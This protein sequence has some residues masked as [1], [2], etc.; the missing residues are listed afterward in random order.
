MLRIE[1]AL[2]FVIQI[3]TSLQIVM[4][5]FADF[6]ILLD[7]N[8]FHSNSSIQTVCVF[9]NFRL[10]KQDCLIKRVAAKAENTIFILAII[11]HVGCFQT[12]T[13][14]DNLDSGFLFCSVLEWGG[15]VVLGQ[16]SSAEASY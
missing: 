1:E 13:T 9:C 11:Q 12:Y 3:E 2:M 10:R 6:V 4:Q 14:S 7:K 16:T 5:K 8:V 15:R